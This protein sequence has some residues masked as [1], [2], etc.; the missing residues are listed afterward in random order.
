MNSNSNEDG[1]KLKVTIEKI[2]NT[3]GGT[4]DDWKLIKDLTNKQ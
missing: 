1:Q 3:N 2:L 4:G